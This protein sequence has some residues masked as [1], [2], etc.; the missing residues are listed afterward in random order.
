MCCGCKKYDQPPIEELEM[1]ATNYCLSKIVHNDQTDC[2]L[3]SYEPNLV[4]KPNISLPWFRWKPTPT[5]YIGYV[6]IHEYVDVF[7][8][9]WLIW[10]KVC[11]QEVNILPASSVLN[12]TQLLLEYY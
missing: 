5:L 4:F 2:T 10:Y 6:Y 8:K 12:R 7:H 9:F 11:T 1:Y 3:V